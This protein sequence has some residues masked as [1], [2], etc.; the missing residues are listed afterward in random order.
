MLVLQIWFDA[1][2]DQKLYDVLFVRATRHM[3]RRR[4]LGVHEVSFGAGPLE[5]KH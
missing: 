2:S 1:A 3:N 5:K 4:Q